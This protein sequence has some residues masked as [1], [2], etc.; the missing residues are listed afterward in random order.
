MKHG[1]MVWFIASCALIIFSLAIPQHCAGQYSRQ[2]NTQYNKQ[3]AQEMQ[4]FKAQQEQKSKNYLAQYDKENGEFMS[5]VGM[6][7]KEEKIMAFRNFLSGQYD[8]N[9][10]FRKEMYDE[11]R[12]FLQKQLDRNPNMQP[13]MKE[14]ML[15]RIDQNYKEATEFYAGKIKEDMEFLDQML[16]DKSIDGQ[17]LNTKLKEFFESQG[18]AGRA[19]AEGQQ[20]QYRNRQMPTGRGQ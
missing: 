14:Q 16:K 8:K 2:Y 15:S 5:T 10:A 3:W 1:H 13:F 4:N 7:Q 19:F 9:C 12:A 17:E 6:M 20:Q 18:A 11:Y